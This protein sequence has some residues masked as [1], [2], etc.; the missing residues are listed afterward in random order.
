MSVE[1][2]WTPSFLFKRYDEYEI[3]GNQVSRNI[4]GFC[5]T[6]EV[7]T[8]SVDSTA[9]QEKIKRGCDGRGSVSVYTSDE[10]EMCSEDGNVNLQAGTGSSSS[11][12]SNN[13]MGSQLINRRKTVV[14]SALER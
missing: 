7:D 12:S 11:S 2:T 5:R 10:D 9:L 3:N 13:S 6:R 8:E 14:A 4:R 1:D